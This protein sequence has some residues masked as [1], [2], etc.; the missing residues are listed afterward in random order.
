MK[1]II[2]LT[3]LLLAPVLAVAQDKPTTKASDKPIEAKAPEKAKP[4]ILDKAKLL[5]LENLSL[6]LQ[7]AQARAEAAIPAELK[8]AAEQAD[9]A[10]AEFWK[11]VGIPR[12]QLS[13]YTVSDGVD[14]A[15][16]AKILTKKEAPTPQLTPSKK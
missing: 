5:E 13:E 15:D 9:T 11:S 1:R 3:I 6:K 12:E 2:F 7:L 8:K 10:I 14:G 4:V 16:G